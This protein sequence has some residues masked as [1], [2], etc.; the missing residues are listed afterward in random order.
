M[1]GRAATAPGQSTVEISLEPDDAGT[2]LRLTHRDLPPGMHKFH[3]IGWDYA[4]PRL[5]MVAAGRDPGPDPLR[6]M[7][8]GAL[9]AARSLPPRYLYRFALRRLRPPRTRR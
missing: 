4:L 9:M 5:A 3:R 8:R 2:R 6:S 7:L 1:G